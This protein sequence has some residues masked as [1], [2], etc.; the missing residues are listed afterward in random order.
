M[1]IMIGKPKFKVG[2]KVKFIAGNKVK[3]GIVEVVD[4]WGTFFDKTDACYDIWVEEEN[5][6]YKHFNEKDI[7]DAER[8][9]LTLDI[10]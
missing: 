3:E 4:K 5:M 9:K 8:Y 6:L 2:D 10:E 7:V 1:W